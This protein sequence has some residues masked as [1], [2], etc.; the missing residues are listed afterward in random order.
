[1]PIAPILL[2]GRSGCPRLRQAASYL[3]GLGF[4][5]ACLYIDID[6]YAKKWLAAYA[7]GCTLPQI[8]IRGKNVGDHTKIVSYDRRHIQELV[9]GK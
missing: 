3:R 7:P 9:G 6:P 4:T 5:A 2:Y 1:M 8:F